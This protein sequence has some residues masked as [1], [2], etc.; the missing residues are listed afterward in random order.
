MTSSIFRVHDG[1]MSR[2]IVLLSVCVVSAAAVAQ[3][4]I[5]SGVG[6]Q[7]LVRT[8]QGCGVFVNPAPPSNPG[9]KVSRQFEWS[10]RCVNGV[11]EGPGQLTEIH[12]VDDR[13]STRSFHTGHLRAGVSL[14]YSE[15]DIQLN[16]EPIG[17]Q[18]S[19]EVEKMNRRNNIG[20]MYRFDQRSVFIRGGVLRVP[21]GAFTSNTIGL[22]LPDRAFAFDENVRMAGVTSF[23][24]VV[25][26]RHVPCRF[27][28]QQLPACAGA[29][30]GRVFAVEVTQ[31]LGPNA[32]VQDVQRMERQLF[33]CPTPTTFDGCHKLFF[34]KAQPVIDE[35]LDLIRTTKPLVEAELA[36]APQ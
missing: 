3:V 22:P 33:Q 21:P 9:Q 34:E 12:L 18:T 20:W 23:S 1:I 27:Y 5:N 15:Y 29:R 10:G 4:S 24:Q 32:T 13:P 6:K 7:E 28:S 31:P 16:F 36:G 26:A 17:A 19:A 8:V 14:G 30:D 2:S 35:I 25:S 11:A